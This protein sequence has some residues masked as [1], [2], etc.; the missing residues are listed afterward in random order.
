MDRIITITASDRSKGTLTLSD[1]GTTNAIAGDQVTWVIGP[2]SGV[3]AILGIVNKPTSVDVFIPDP[4]LQP[5][6]TSWMGTINPDI[7]VE[8]EEQYSIIWEAVGGGWHGQNSGPY[9]FDPTIKVKP[10]QR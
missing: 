9:T 3:A 7:S 5:G 8:T 10:K 1:Q 2:D 6:Q 4:T